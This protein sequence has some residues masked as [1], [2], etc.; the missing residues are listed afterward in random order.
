MDDPGGG[1]QCAVQDVHVAVDHLCRQGARAEHQ[2][3]AHAGQDAV[4]DEL[5]FA[6]HLGRNVGP[7]R[8]VGGWGADPVSYTTLTLPANRQGKLQV[9]AGSGKKKSQDV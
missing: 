5:E 1:L 4:L 3:V 7:H 8:G 6:K 9:C 2:A